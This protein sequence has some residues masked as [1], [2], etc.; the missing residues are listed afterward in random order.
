MDDNKK[1]YSIDEIKMLLTPVF[2]DYGI[3][4][5]ILF[6][7]YSKGTADAKS[8]VDILVDSGLRGLSFVGLIED[9]RQSLQGKDA[10]VFDMTH[11]DHGSLVE[12]EIKNTGVEIYAK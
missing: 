9:I 7:S 4:R 2:M 8:D 6:G 5:A 11:I 1:I 12:N 3:K 10:D